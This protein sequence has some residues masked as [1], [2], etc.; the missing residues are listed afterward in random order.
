MNEKDLTRYL[1]G[2]KPDELTGDEMKETLD[3]IIGEG[4]GT[5]LASD[6]QMNLIIKLADQLEFFWKK[7]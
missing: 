6:K 1:N 5:S 3:L 4:G 2:K 7:L